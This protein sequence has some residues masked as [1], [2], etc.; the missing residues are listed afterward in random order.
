NEWKPDKQGALSATLTLNA[1]GMQG[2]LQ[3]AGQKDLPI[4]GR[5]SAELEVHGS[6]EAPEATLSASLRDGHIY[7][8]PFDTVNLNATYAGNELKVSESSLRRGNAVAQLK[9]TYSHEAGDYKNGH[10]LVSLALREWKLN[11]LTVIREQKTG[12]EPTIAG[13]APAGFQ[14]CNGTPAENAIHARVQ[15]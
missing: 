5:P 9:G 13:V 12:T 2:I 7:D 6:L 8:E 11:D 3:E 1:T 10:G 4:D 15:F 14:L